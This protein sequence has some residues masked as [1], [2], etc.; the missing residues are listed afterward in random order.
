M[1]AFIKAILAYDD[2]ADVHGLLGRVSAYYGCVEAQGRGTLHCHMMIWIDGAL[3]P[4][5]IKERILSDLDGEFQKRLLAVL[6]DTIAN[7]VPED[8]G[9]IDVTV[10]SNS[11][12]ACSVRGPNLAP[13]DPRLG[14]ARQKDLRNVVRKCQMHTHSRT[15]YKY[16][17]GP[18]EPQECRFD[19]DESNYCAESTVDRETGELNLRCLDGLVNNYNPTMLEALRCN[20]DIKFIGSG[21]SA[22][23]ILYYVTDYI[24][25]SPLKAHVSFAALELAVRKLRESEAH[26]DAPL[27]T[28]AKAKALL[29]KCAYAMISHQELSSQQVA[30]YLTDEEDHFSSHDFTHIY[31]P[32]FALS[33]F[34]RHI[35]KEDPSPECDTRNETMAVEAAPDEPDDDTVPDLVDQDSDDESEDEDT[36]RIDLHVH[37][38]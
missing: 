25:K 29:Q 9:D 37:N 38:E 7:C 5:E 1:H 4:N 10:P 34:E 11:H 33:H 17:K 18:P 20:M 2:K 36:D 32:S 12:H 23:A 26:L 24:T 27:D 21:P 28:V 13:D 8:P 3:N 31:W 15:C 16:W 35:E 22:K 14:Q 6:D 30:S 19:L